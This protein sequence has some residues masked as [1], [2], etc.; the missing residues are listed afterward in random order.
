[1]NALLLLQ[2]FRQV[3]QGAEHH[4]PVETDAVMV[5]AVR[6]EPDRHGHIPR[7]DTPENRAR[8]G[9][10]VKVA[11]AMPN[12]PLLILNGEDEQFPMMVD[13][14]VELGARRNQIITVACGAIGTANTKTQFEVLHAAPWLEQIRHLTIVTTGYHVPRVRRTA[15]A[16]LPAGL[17][18]TVLAVPYDDYPFSVF[19][20]R[21]E[22]QRIMQYAAK[23]DIAPF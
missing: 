17:R 12:A 15:K 18:A 1:M 14:A 11:N 2:E 23:G 7:H 4:L 6:P 19:K 8:I 20:V 9:F 10:G 5:L 3:L 16:Q 22:I 13:V 21:G